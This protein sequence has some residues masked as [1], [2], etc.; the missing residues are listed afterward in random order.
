MRKMSPKSILTDCVYDVSCTVQP[1]LRYYCLR[2]KEKGDNLIL[3]SALLIYKINQ[4]GIKL[5][6][7]AT[8]PESSATDQ[9]ELRREMGQL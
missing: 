4:K 5:P 2:R 3:E 7:R 8:E 6:D 9:L 1:A